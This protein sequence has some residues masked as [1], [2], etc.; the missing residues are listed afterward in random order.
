MPTVSER[1]AKNISKTHHQTIRKD[2]INVRTLIYAI[3]DDEV[4][5]EGS[6]CRSLET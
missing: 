3:V 4:G 1:E 2:R 6:N 5:G